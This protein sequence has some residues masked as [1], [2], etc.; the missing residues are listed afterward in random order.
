M[1]DTNYDPDPLVFPSQAWFAAYEDE[2]DD[3]G[4]R[5]ASGDRSVGFDV[6]LVFEMTQMPVDELDVDTMPGY[7]RDEL[8]TYVTEDDETGYTGYAYLG[9][10][11]GECTGARLLED[12]EEVEYDFLLS[13]TAAK[14][15]SLLN[16]ELGI[17]DGL[18][19]GGFELDGNVRT[20]LQY[21]DSVARLR[22]LAASIDAEF[23][24]DWF[25]TVEIG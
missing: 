19:G 5:T 25:R 23:A 16:G 1:V 6:D 13:A 24:D 17:V 8:D 18:M 15:K 7:L 20:I 2:I 10:E 14:W 11:G 21:S 3:E 9:L 12:P 4:Y 22:E